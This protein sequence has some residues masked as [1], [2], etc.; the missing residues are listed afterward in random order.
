[1]AYADQKAGN[2]R[3]VALI[4][5]GLLHVLIG[6]A[7]ISGLAYKYV[8][9]AVED[10]E[11]FDVEEPPPPPEEIPPP[12]PPPDQPQPQSPPP[13]VTPPPIVQNPNPPPVQMQTQTNPPPSYVP[14]PTA[15]PPAPPAPVAP[16]A[17]PAPV[18]SKAAGPRS[19]PATWFTNDDYP[20]SALNSGDEG[21]TAIA[22]DI[23][24][25]GRV[26]NCRVTASSGS[27]ALDRATCA[28]LQRR[29][30]FTPALDQSGNPIR[31]TGSRRVRWTMPADR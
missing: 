26:E 16:P 6:Y 15:G 27:A 12:P 14:I 28:T 7:F 30:R 5:V 4:I 31:S 23:N 18:I 17:P 8:K 2:G 22:W 10:T 1:M 29:A 24:T 13:V 25:Q 3:I 9:K 19:D 20:A 11:T 21:V